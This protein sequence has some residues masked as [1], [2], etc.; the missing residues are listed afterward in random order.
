[1]IWLGLLQSPVPS[2]SSHVSLYA[3][4]IRNADAGLVVDDLG[5]ARGAFE[6]AGQISP[7]NPTVAYGLAC[8][9]GRSGSS[10]E[11]LELLELATQ[12]G[13]IDAFV[14]QWDPDLAS[15]RADPRFEALAESWAGALEPQ[16]ARARPG[17]PWRVITSSREHG[18][19]VV[20]LSDDAGHVAV[21]HLD[22]R[23]VLLDGATGSVERELLRLPARPWAVE[24]DP[25]GNHLALLGH[26]G[27]L[28]VLAVDGTSASAALEAVPPSVLD[29]PFQR[30][31]SWSPSGEHLVVVVSQGDASL[32]S[33]SGELVARWTNQGPDCERRTLW[34]PRDEQ[35]LTVEG[36][37]VQVRD[38]HTGAL[39][40]EPV[41]CPSEI[42]GLASSPDGRRIA[43]GWADG[44]IALW[45]LEGGVELVRKQF[46]DP[47]VPEPEDHVPVLA[48]SAQGDQL[49][50]TTREGSWVEV[51]DSKNLRTLWRSE[52]Q[53]AHFFEAM[54]VGWSAREPRIWFAFECGTGDIAT[55][56]PGPHAKPLSVG[57]G[58]I[59]VFHG[60]RGAFV[61]ERGVTL[62]DAGSPHLFWRRM[63]V[64]G[65]A[66]IQSSSAHF[67]GTWSSL[68]GLRVLD[69]HSGVSVELD[70]DRIEQLFDPKRV[71]ACQ[72][73]VRVAVPE[74]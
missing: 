41:T 71:R 63:E 58:T 73:G 3:E 51:T 46:V 5:L 52:F 10:D 39:L 49:A 74:L 16:L 47:V 68:E 25:S 70:D 38:G 62:V 55:L 56:R 61:H 17:W 28:R 35:L 6:V 69:P 31:L 12:W 15:V 42:K 26:D 43:V 57:E 22:G 65:G 1:M 29:Y 21:A 40:S 64:P 13:W 54:P 2:P 30:K 4:A 27:R 33:R 66:L 8:I 34:L 60:N 50:W 20:A 67:C 72:A 19:E 59:P 11:A 48:F 45:D 18:A 44:W 53:G 9:A 23:L 32:W 7:H 37:K 14:A 36:S 24:F